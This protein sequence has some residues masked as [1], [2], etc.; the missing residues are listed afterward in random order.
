MSA[1]DKILNLCWKNTA[2][3]PTIIET[4]A[5]STRKIAKW[6]EKNNR[7]KF[8]SIDLDGRLQAAV[9]KELE[10]EGTAKYCTF[11]TQYPS[12]Y[13]ANLTWVDCAFL[14]P[15]DL[16]RGE[17]EFSLVISAGARIVAIDDYQV[18]A[19]SAVNLAKKLG[20]EVKQVED[21]FV[22]SRPEFTK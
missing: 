5:F 15:P 19:A 21:Y 6:V 18:R 4:G 9:H 10:C 7:S 16:Q 11:H 12:K 1:V 8:E 17:E 3:Y 22:L 20:W 2:V 13:L 14:H